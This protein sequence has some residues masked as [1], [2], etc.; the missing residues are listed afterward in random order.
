MKKVLLS[1]YALVIYTCAVSQQAITPFEKS[2]GKKTASYEEIIHFYNHLGKQFRTICLKVFHSTDSGFPLNLVLFSSDKT[3]DPKEWHKKGKIVVLV[4]NG[5]H[6]GEPDGIDASMM[7]LRDLANGKI[8]APDNVVLAVIPVY[9]VGGALNRNSFSRVNQVGPESYGFRG[10]GQNL[11]LNRD[12]TKN[13]S[14]NARAFAQIFHYLNPDIFIDNH[15]SDG[16][17]YQHT[18]T[19]LST[20]HNKL[21]NE[22]GKFLHDTL[23]PA[24]YTGMANKNFPLTPYV[25][26]EEGSPDKGWAAFCDPP[27]YSSGYTT[28]FQTI[29]FTSETHMLKP[30]AD[31]VWS[32][33]ALMQTML[34]ETAKKSKEIINARKQSIKA[35]QQQKDF[36]LSWKLDT[37]FHDIIH[38]KGYESGYK[39]SEVTGMDRL[40]YDKSKPFE[41]EVKYYNTFAG[42]QWVTAPKYYIIPQGWWPVLDILKLNKVEMKRL[43]HDSLI[44]VEAYRIEDYKS[45]AKPYE[46]HHKNYNVSVVKNTQKI[47]FL[48]GDYII[49]CDQRAR[50]YLVEML[51]PTGD[52][53]FFAWNFFDAVLQQ[54]EGYSAYRWEDVAAALLKERPELKK[55]LE[56]KKLADTVFAASAAAQLD[57]VYKNSPYYEPAHL[58]YPVYRIP[59]N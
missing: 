54:K 13:D 10:N 41:K 24:L 45:L 15:V 32:T 29:G 20:Q 36:P 6:A 17:D 22:L 21:G 5:I 12:F 18:M 35:T 19:L 8:T 33:Y 40:Y 16:A 25:S 23:E 43:P 55:I 39:K 51:E 31:R 38:F 1:I 50:R 3:F 26:F 28:L 56:E 44:E 48:K 49:N 57:F 47:K 58:R 9:N 59:A 34:E 37:S 53:S 27:R 11:D 30:F 2:S 42:H 7:L 52:D 4:N 14:K 46:K